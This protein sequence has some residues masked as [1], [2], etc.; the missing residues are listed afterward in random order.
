[1]P[2]GPAVDNVGNGGES[3]HVVHDG[4]LRVQPGHGRKGRLQAGLAPAAFQGAEE[5]RLLAAY[6]S[7]CSP[8]DDDLLVP[9][10]TEDVAANVALRSGCLQSA[11]QNAVASLKLAPDINERARR[12]N[13]KGAKEQALNKLMG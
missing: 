11:L 2:R 7:P 9:A 5:A 4:R 1:K 6:V 3:L 8:V 13:G 12:P 10:R